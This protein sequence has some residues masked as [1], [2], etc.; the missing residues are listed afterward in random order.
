MKQNKTPEKIIG[1][2]GELEGQIK[3][4]LEAVKLAYTGLQ[5]A[6]A[7]QGVEFSL[8]PEAALKA[9]ADSV[10]IS[11]T[12]EVPTAKRL[13]LLGINP[14][15]IT[16]AA[17]ALSQACSAVGISPEDLNENGE[18]SE[19]LRTELMSACVVK[20]VGEDAVRLASELE[21]AAV[22][23]Q[24]FYRLMAE[25]GQNRPN[26]AAVGQVFNGMLAMGVNGECRIVP[27]MLHLYVRNN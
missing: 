18:V 13:D 24:S 17:Y 9:A 8:D 11:G 2:N 10:Q 25:R 15:A 23:V 26:A 12:R 3:R 27:H 4:N 16:S 19:D 20:A 14:A 21:K 7:S 22:A 1:W 5:N 6:Y